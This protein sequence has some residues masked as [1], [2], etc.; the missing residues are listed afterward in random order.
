MERH[1]ME[2]GPSTHYIS[3]NYQSSIVHMQNTQQNKQKRRSEVIIEASLPI[4]QNHFLLCATIARFHQG[5]ERLLIEDIIRTIHYENMS[6]H[7][8]TGSFVSNLKSITSSEI[9][10]IPYAWC[11][12]FDTSLKLSIN[13]PVLWSTISALSLCAY[14]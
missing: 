6:L 7:P 8:F 12:Y 14:N 5:R 11:F 3:T 1:C 10:I 4:P 9:K 13:V 2:T